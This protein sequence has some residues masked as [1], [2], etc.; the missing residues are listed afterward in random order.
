MSTFEWL[1]IEKGN[2]WGSVYY[3]YA[4]KGLNK[5]GTA[6]AD[7]GL[8]LEAGRT[9]MVMWPDGFVS[10]ARLAAKDYQEEVMD[11]GKSY[12]A[13][14]KLY[15]VEVDNHGTVMWTE[16]TALKFPSDA[17]QVRGRP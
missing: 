17:F 15:G 9:V 16:I 13:N 5:W 8:V 10:Q 12:M 7:C 3:A 14:S 11:H 6:S 4:G 1:G 2:D